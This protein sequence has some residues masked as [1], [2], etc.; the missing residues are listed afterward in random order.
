LVNTPD[1]FT[2][3]SF[4]EGNT[5]YAIFE[6]K[7]PVMYRILSLVV[8]IT[9]IGIIPGCKGEDFYVIDGFTQG[10]TYHIVYRA[11]E[12]NDPATVRSG[13]EDLFLKVDRSLSVYNDSSV[14]SRIN[15]NTSDETDSLFRE[16]FRLSYDV[17][18]E[19]GG[20]FDITVGPLVKAWGFG[21]DAVK[22]F[23]PTKL[24]S[25]LSLVGMEKVR[26]DGNKLVK[27][28]PIMY[29]DMNAVAQGFTVDLAIRY[30]ESLGINDCLVEV[31]GE[32]GSLGNKNGEGWKVGIDKPIDGNNEP[33]QDMEAVIRLDNKALAT[34]G[35]YRKFYID[36][37]IKYSH[38]IDPHTGYPARQS[39][40]SATIVA[41]DCATADAYATACMVIG[42][43]KAKEL[44]EKHNFLDGYLIWSDEKGSL[45]V[46]ASE[47][48]RKD[49]REIDRTLR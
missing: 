3:V 31:G 32:V 12:K 39:L 34:S 22:R 10:S 11:S 19:T 41:S 48:I 28:S 8:L 4:F 23:D 33:G 45:M 44:I 42:T 1:L 7:K 2:K 17:W 25:L 26:L 30:L 21:P 37:G 49:I 36:N 40:L 14:I 46:W 47:R 9:I 38:T 6:N 43:D 5:L 27:N 16:V 20:A 24:Q 29:I 15:S 13:L 18:K 35:N